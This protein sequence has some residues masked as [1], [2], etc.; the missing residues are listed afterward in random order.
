M[1]KNIKMAQEIKRIQVLDHIIRHDGNKT[2]AEALKDMQLKQGEG[3]RRTPGGVPHMPY[4][5]DL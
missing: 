1:K 2:Y 4:T 3:L 5:N